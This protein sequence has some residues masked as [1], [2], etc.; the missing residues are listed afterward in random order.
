MNKRLLHHL[1]T[2]LRPLKTRYF[3]LAC[4]VL[5][6]I[7]VLSL[8]QNYTTMVRLRNDV[9]AADRNDSNVIGALNKLRSFVNGHMN[10]SLSADTSVYPPV[11]LTETYNRLKAAEDARVKNETAKVYND[12]QQHCEALYPASFSGG[13]RV[14]CVEQYVKDHVVVAREI[15]AALYK[16]DFSTPRWSPDLAGISMALAILFGLLAVLRLAAG[17]LLQ[18]LTR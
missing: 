8:R 15:P 17:L 4:L 9:Y 18:R 12:A 14:P 16:F 13:P 11:Q 10:T 7:C 2:R 3:L 6:V 5:S 1:W